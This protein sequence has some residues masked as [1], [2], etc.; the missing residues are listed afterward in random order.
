MIYSLVILPKYIGGKPV[1]LARC[2]VPG[3]DL[4]W[5]SLLVFIGD[6]YEVSTDHRLRD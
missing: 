2:S 4:S 3:T 1:L 6:R 5:T